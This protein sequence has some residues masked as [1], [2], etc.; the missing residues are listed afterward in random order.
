MWYAIS[1]I[2]HDFYQVLCSNSYTIDMIIGMWKRKRAKAFK[3]RPASDLR[4]EV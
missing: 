1:I 4:S 3:K 2:E